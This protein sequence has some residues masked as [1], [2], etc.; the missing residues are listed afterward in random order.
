MYSTDSR[1]SCARRAPGVGGKELFATLQGVVGCV[2]SLL[3]Q[4]AW[5][6]AAPHCAGQRAVPQAAAMDV[7][8][9]ESD[10]DGHEESD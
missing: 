8:D 9:E 4:W 1:S 10:E 3:G 2:M 5:I 7:D 6:P